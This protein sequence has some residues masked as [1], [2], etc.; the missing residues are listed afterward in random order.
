M[1]PSAMKTQMADR[2]HFFSAWY[3]LTAAQRARSGKRYRTHL[4]SA[5]ETVV[6]LDI[7]NEEAVSWETNMVEIVV[8]LLV[9]E[10]GAY[11]P[12]FTPNAVK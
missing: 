2:Y 8:S 11:Q 12:I 9:L 4:K 7:A 10:P 6:R 5:R 1:K 3:H